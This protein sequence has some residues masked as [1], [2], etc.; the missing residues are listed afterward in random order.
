MVAVFSKMLEGTR[1]RAGEVRLG[2]I[3]SKKEEKSLLQEWINHEMLEL[4]RCK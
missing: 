2:L 1:G 4:K 3:G